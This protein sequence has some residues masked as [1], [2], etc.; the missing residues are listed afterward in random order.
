MQLSRNVLAGL[1]SSVWSALIGLAVV[2]LYLK[3]LGIEAYG[4]IGFFVTLQSLLQ[5]LD[6]GLSA[7]INREVARSSALGDPRKIGH[8]LH[9]LAVIYWGMGAA[10]AFI[11]VTS[12]TFIAEHWLQSQRLSQ[13]DISLAVMLMGMVIAFRWPIGLYQGVLMGAQ[14]LVEVSVINTV[15]GTTGSLGAVAVLAF[16]S[17]TI[18][19]FFTWQAAVALV[20]VAVVRWVGWR[21]I[22]RMED[23]QFR[24]SELKRVWRFSAGMSGITLSALVFTQLDKVLLSKILGLEEF[25]HYMLATVVVGSLYVLVTPIFN[26]IYPRFSALVQTNNLEKLTEVYRSGT[27]MLGTVLF[28]IAMILVVLGEELVRIWIGNPT[29]ASSVAPVIGL[30]AVGSALHG[31]MYFPYSLQLAYGM[32]K[33]PLMINAILIVILVPV[34][35]VLSLSYG[36]IGGAIAWLVLHILYLIIGTSLTHRR[37]LRKVGRVWLL[38]EVGVP[39]IFSV[40]T[41]LA[42]YYA[43]HGEGYSLQ[44]KLLCGVMFAALASLLSA[45]ASPQLRTLLLNVAGWKK[46]WQ[47]S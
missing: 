27:R 3:H 32:T 16:F 33:L 34:I 2:P 20:T 9:T 31:V 36:A 18:Q 24:F 38:E 1:A 46:R 29:I 37:L 5:L 28:P 21:A 8:L 4:L 23:L 7:T 19:A 45:A 22:G 40:L 26:A 35:I 42:T 15:M 13:Q 10:I 6:L 17:P 43:I 25:G 44:W 12:A 14:R 39:L 11:L 47:I 30:L 41:G